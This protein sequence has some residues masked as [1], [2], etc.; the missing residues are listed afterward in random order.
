MNDR[1]D[2]T[3]L[4]SLLSTSGIWIRAVCL[5]VLLIVFQIGIAQNKALERET[6]RRFQ[7]ALTGHAMVQISYILP[8]YVCIVCLTI[9]AILIYTMRTYYPQS[10]YSAVGPLLRPSEMM[11]GTQSLPG[12]FYFVIGTTITLLLIDDMTIARYSIECLSIA[13]PI[14]SWIGSTIRSPKL[15]KSGNTSMAGCIGCFIASWIIGYM[16][17][18]ESIYSQQQQQQH[19]HDG[20]HQYNLFRTITIGALA[21]TVA[22][23]LPL[24][25]DNLNIPVATAFVVEKLGRR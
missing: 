3:S 25:N 24:G 14:A 1:Q 2:A 4:S 10:F 7:H 8:K 15:T 23:G 18:D 22:E 13:D 19:V 21:C 9:G 20:S 17:L 6:K 16:M 11:N 12:A 5:T